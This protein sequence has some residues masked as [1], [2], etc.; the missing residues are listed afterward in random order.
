MI[1]RTIKIERS[2]TY[3]VCSSAHFSF[4]FPYLAAIVFSFIYSS[5]TLSAA[6]VFF[7]HFLHVYNPLLVCFTHNMISGINCAALR[8]EIDST[9][10]NNTCC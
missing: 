5:N 8:K 7:F 3:W 6:S 10:Y 9:E 2:N 1:S 4:F